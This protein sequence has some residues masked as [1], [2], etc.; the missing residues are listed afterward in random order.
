MDPRPATPE[1]LRLKLPSSNK[2]TGAS[3]TAQHLKSSH[4][5]C[6]HISSTANCTQG[7][8]LQSKESFK[9]GGAIRR[10]SSP[11]IFASVQLGHVVPE[12]AYYNSSRNHCNPINCEHDPKCFMPLAVQ[13]A[14][15]H[16]LS[17][18]PNRRSAQEEDPE[19][20]EGAGSSEST[21]DHPTS[22]EEEG[23]GGGVTSNEQCRE[24]G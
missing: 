13:A 14:A 24:E 3:V 2:S 22:R 9:A 16:H 18:P 15:G 21:R 10:G 4:Q 23:E 11:R 1:H 20:Q 7:Q 12:G 6:L 17:P 19:P 5:E 8:T